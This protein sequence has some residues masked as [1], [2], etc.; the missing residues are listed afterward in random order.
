MISW[1]FVSFLEI[2]EVE[3]IADTTEE[4]GIEETGIVTVDRIGD[5]VT[6]EGTTGETIVEMIVGMTEIVTGETTDGMID[7]MIGET[8]GVM[9][10]ETAEMVD[11]EDINCAANNLQG[12]A[13]IAAFE[14]MQ[15]NDE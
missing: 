6:I 14:M 9:T 15:F 10:G 5:R 1:T 2:L 8:T 4:I 7:G 13:T 11:L 12:T 3:G